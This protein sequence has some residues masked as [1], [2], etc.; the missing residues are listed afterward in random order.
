VR[1]DGIRMPNRSEIC[2]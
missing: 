1:D 2:D